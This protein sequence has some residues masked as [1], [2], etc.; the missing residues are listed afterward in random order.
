[1]RCHVLLN[2]RSGTAQELAIT[3][4]DLRRRLEAAGLE[5]SLDEDAEH[6]LGERVAKALKQDAKLLIAAGGDGTVTALARGVIDSSRI[7]GVLPLG[8]ANLLA[9]DLSIPL[10]LDQWIET[11]SSMG[12]RR[13]DVGEVNGHIF[14]H[15]A[16]IGFVP[17]IAAGRELI[18]GRSDVGAQVGFLLYF[19]RR[20]LRARRLT[21]EVKPADGPPRIRRVQALAVASNAYEEGFARFF[22]RPRLDAGILT[23]YILKHLSLSDLARLFVAKLMGRWRDDDALEIESVEA[24]TIRS[25]RNFLKVMIDGEVD[26]LE[27]PL[28]FTIRPGA[29]K[30]LAS[31]SAAQGSKSE[32]HPEQPAAEN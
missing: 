4:E 28:H 27:T 30:V 31:P 1:M 23:L 29:L 10:D 9:R 14:L 26:T 6:P 18:R 8:T 5:V 24:V 15:K 19:L 22:S 7:L 12:P 2:A 11:F 32:A 17:G 21:V 25:R 16:V 3:G 13:I 20:L